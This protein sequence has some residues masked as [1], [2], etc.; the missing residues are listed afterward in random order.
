[1]N[2]LPELN[3][4]I[5]EY[6][7]SEPSP[8][9]NYDEGTKKFTDGANPV[10]KQM[11]MKKF[12]WVR[13]IVEQSVNENDR[14]PAALASY[15]DENEIVGVQAH[16]LRE[17]LDQKMQP[18]YTLKEVSAEKIYDDYPASFSWR[19]LYHKLCFEFML[20]NFDKLLNFEVFYDYVNKLG[21][22]IEVLRVRTLNKTKLKSNHYWVMVL[23]TKL[24]KLRVLKLHGNQVCHVGPDFF[25]FLLKGMNYMQKEGRQLEKI[26]MSK[27][28]GTSGSPGDNLFPCLKPHQNLVSLDFSH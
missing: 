12:D 17:S 24:T 19:D 5:K 20:T 1:M 10:W 13:R 11:C 27:L 18:A 16:S 8:F 14:K 6:L 25:K 21:D 26:Q 2:E 4:Q 22:S 7:L 3:E 28:L 23:M 15:S 9:A